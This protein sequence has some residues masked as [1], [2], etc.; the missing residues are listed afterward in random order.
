M[1]FQELFGTELPIIQAP[2]AG[3]Q[4]HRLAAAV[5]AAGGLGSLPCGLL[6]PTEVAAELRALTAATDGPYN[7]NF[8]CHVVPAPDPD[9]E[10]RWRELL[11]PYYAELG[12]DLGADAVGRFRAPFGDAAAAV[13]E[14]LR[15]P[16][17]AK[18]AG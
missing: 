13:V 3:V 6:E 7:L 15:P 17:V 4:D 8:F 14:E 10:A 12:L 1:T 2:M 9:G 18:I 11:A 16:V 5:S